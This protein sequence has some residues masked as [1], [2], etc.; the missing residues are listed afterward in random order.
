MIYQCSFRFFYHFIVHLLSHEVVNSFLESCAETTKRHHDVTVE[1]IVKCQMAHIT[2]RKRGWTS[3]EYAKAIELIKVIFD[4][5][6]VILEEESALESRSNYYYNCCLSKTESTSPLEDGLI[7]ANSCLHKYLEFK[8]NKG[9]SPL[10]KLDVPITLLQLAR[11]NRV[12]DK[13]IAAGHLERALSLVE[14]SLGNHDFTLC[15][16]KELG[17]LLFDQEKHQEALRFYDRAMTIHENL[18]ATNANISSVHLI[19]NYGLCL[20]NLSRFEEAL[21]HVREASNIVEKLSEDYDRSKKEVERAL[22][23]IREKQKNG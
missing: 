17:D 9:Q 13:S 22:C 3:D 10:E 16:Y 15:C 11:V 6:E 5:G 7:Q 1:V 19:K 14:I 20:S 12:F 2:G 23:E 8:E 18:G 21:C 4:N